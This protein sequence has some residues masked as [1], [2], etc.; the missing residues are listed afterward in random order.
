MAKRM[1]ASELLPQGIDPKPLS[2]GSGAD[3]A[4]LLG[5]SI[6]ASPPMRTADALRSMLASNLKQKG[7]DKLNLSEFRAPVTDAVPDTKPKPKEEPKPPQA[8]GSAAPQLRKTYQINDGDT[9]AKVQALLDEMK[10]GAPIVDRRNEYLGSPAMDTT[11]SGLADLAS[12][13]GAASGWAPAAAAADRAKA[14]GQAAIQQPYIDALKEGKVYKMPIG[15][16]VENQNALT[17]R[18]QALQDKATEYGLATGKVGV[19]ADLGLGEISSANRRAELGSEAALDLGNLREQ[20]DTARSNASNSTQMTIAKMND[21]TNRMQI[22]AMAQRDLLKALAESNDPAKIEKQMAA[23]LSL[24]DQNTAIPND[25]KEL[26]KAMVQDN[27]RNT[28]EILQR[29]GLY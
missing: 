15:L 12:V 2:P 7:L 18:V 10:A 29:Y 24:I 16:T 19:Q 27:P 5:L 1:F 26:I 22:Q 4:Q 25:K 21:E 3:L 6:Q 8:S 9:G 28:I 23:G 20:G 17:D 13:F 14:I 11:I